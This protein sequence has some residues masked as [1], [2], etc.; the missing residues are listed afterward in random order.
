MSDTINRDLID[1]ILKY[2]RKEGKITDLDNALEKIKSILSKWSKKKIFGIRI[3]MTESYIK[4]TSKGFFSG[5]CNHLSIE[6]KELKPCLKVTFVKIIDITQNLIWLKIEKPQLIPLTYINYIDINLT[7]AQ[8]ESFKLKFIDN[9]EIR[10]HIP[11]IKTKNKKI[12][13]P[14]CN[15]YNYNVC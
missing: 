10:N 6:T 8:I 15:N 9:L 3:A 4:K 14:C 2:W 11:L 5:L 7:P 12:R 13:Q 1:N